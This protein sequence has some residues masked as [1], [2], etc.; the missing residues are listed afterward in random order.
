[1]SELKVKTVEN[2]DERVVLKYTQDVEPA[3]IAAA[4]ARR[5]DRERGAFQRSHDMKRTMVIPFAIL[6]QI[7]RETGLSYLN[8]EDS[9][10]IAKILKGPDYAKFRTTDKAR[11]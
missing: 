8:K 9:K 7:E 11:R 3:L 1:L 10:I 5:E 6:M 2:N 4:D